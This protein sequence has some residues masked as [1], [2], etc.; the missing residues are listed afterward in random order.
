MNAIEIL[1]AAKKQIVDK[2]WTQGAYARTASGR[3]IG[4]HAGAAAC[5]CAIGA[6]QSVHD[7][8]HAAH[9]EAIRLLRLQ[10]LNDSD[11]PT[12]ND[13]PD[14]TKEEVIAAFDKAITAAEGEAS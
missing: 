7:D 13:H 5:F 6:C 2:G 1:K 3:Q 9:Y 8:Y 11:I 4:A 14:R 10:T 12:W